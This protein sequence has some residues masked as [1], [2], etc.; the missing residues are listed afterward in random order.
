M[1]KASSVPIQPQEDPLDPLSSGHFALMEKCETYQLSASLNVMGDALMFYEA[2]LGVSHKTPPV[3]TLVDSGASHT[4]ISE[5]TVRELGRAI[6]PSTW[7]QTV[8]VKLPNGEELPTNQSIRLP[9]R[10]GTWRGFVTA[11]VLAFN[12]YELILGRDFLRHVNPDINWVN[13]RM[14][15]RE[16]GRT[17]LITPAQSSFVLDNKDNRFNLISAKQCGRVTRKKNS[18]AVLFVVRTLPNQADVSD[19]DPIAHKDPRIQEILQRHRSVFRSSLPNELPPDRRIAHKIDTKDA[20][21][22]NINAYPLSAEKLNEQARQIEELVQKGLIRPSSSPWGF[23]VIFV[24]KHN[25]SWRMCIDYRALNRLTV[26][27]GYPLPRIQ[28]LLDKVGTARVLSKIDLASGYW[29]IR[30]GDKSIE[31]TA[32]N[33]MWGKYE[34]LAMPF[35][36]CNAPAT[37]QTIMNETLQPL[38]GKCVVVYLDDILIYSQSL[39]DHYKH[40]DQ[41]L[42]LLEKQKLYAQPQKCEFAPAHME[43]CGHIIGNGTLRPMPAKVDAIREW[44]RPKNVHDVRQ[45]IGLATYYR[46]FIPG[47]AK[48]CVPLHELLKET[49]ATLRQRKFRPIR[50]TVA[51]ESAFR[52]LKDLLVCAPVLIQPDQTKPFVIETDAS[53]WAIGMV[54]L[55]S[56]ANGKLHPVAFDGRKLQGAE[57]NYPVHEKELLAI[58]EALRL[59][60]R[61]IDNGTRTTIVTDHASLQYLQTTKTYSKRLARWVDE[62]QEYDLKIEYR[63]GSDAVVPDAISRR[64][65]FIEDGPANVSKSRPIWDASLNI[66][67][68]VM[69]VPEEEWLAATEHY[70]DIKKLPVDKSLANAVRKYAPKLSWQEL[71]VPMR[72]TNAVNRQLFFTHDDGVRAPY[73]EPVMRGDLLQR[74]HKEFGHLGYPGLNGVVRPRA[75][76]PTMRQEIEEIAKN[77]PNCQV[78]QGSHK[79]LEREAAQHMVTAGI[80]PFERWGIDLIGRLPTTPNGNRWIITAIDYAT[81]WPV[82]KAV[83]DAT[84]ETI[85]EFLHEQLFI[86]YGAPKEIISDNGPNLISGAVRY[87]LGLLETR[88]KTTTP[89][90]PRTN[91]K[92]ENLNGLLGRMLTKYLMNKPTKA[93]DLYLPQALF[94]ARVHEHA[95]TGFSPFFLVYGVHPRIPSDGPSSIESPQQDRTAQLQTLSDARTKA[96]ELLLNRAIRTN[97][98]RDSLVT[99]TSFQPGDWVLIRNESGKKFESKWFG[100]YKVIQ[101][102]PLGTYALSEPNGHVL[103]YLV[104]GSRLLEANVDDPKSLWTSSAARSALRRAGLRVQRPEEVRKIL[105]SDEPPPSYPDLST[106]TRQEWDEF[107]RTGARLD[108]VGE[109]AA[110]E[111]VIAK[112]R[113]NAKK[114]RQTPQQEAEVVEDEWDS[115]ENDY[116]STQSESNGSNQE[117]DVSPNG[118]VHHNRDADEQ[119]GTFQGPFAV[120]IPKRS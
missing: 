65:D 13:S 104:N 16:R 47:F 48:I 38:L 8:K 113:A 11:W 42:S 73:L 62:F 64:P 21:A 23:P 80:R 4:F 111:R 117:E 100:P 79:S 41:V 97:K 120:V 36:L 69:K 33:T 55:Q 32:F 101:S 115:E 68:M 119:D 92:V 44:P 43:F 87:Y 12:E 61:Y 3:T 46:R 17:H 99:K 49:D 37:F 10:M 54:L 82:A 94:A 22:V 56:D 67:R 76:W 26:K 75:W 118:N 90:H 19:Q 91:G 110:A 58:K 2:V 25:G 45:F 86:Q 39:E 102:H 103:R 71:K 6:P 31:K 83:P 34:W 114:R 89:Y 15:I 35:G 14:K 27:N 29:Q 96:N 78:S 116:E 59:W 72:A 57:L 84:E 95:V 5:R 109:K 18:E 20:K 28:E 74:L 40:L 60:D 9:I 70:L 85:G 66:T 52:K 1:K 24:K 30:M 51:C 105:E 106:F 50:W 7:K 112:S 63:K 77:C 108:S 98:V 53:E 93:W 88:H 81:G 107:K